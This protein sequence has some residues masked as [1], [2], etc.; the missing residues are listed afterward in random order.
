[1]IQP[2]HIFEMMKGN[3]VFALQR[4]AEGAEWKKGAEWLKGYTD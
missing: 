4:R 2:E 3:F 1:M